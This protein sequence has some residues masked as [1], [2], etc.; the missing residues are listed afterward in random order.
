M[1]LGVDAGLPS[2]PLPIVLPDGVACCRTLQAS[3]LAKLLASNITRRKSEAVRGAMVRD[4]A[5]P[6][7]PTLFISSTVHDLKDIRSGLADV[8]RS[9]G[10]IVYASEAEEFEIRGDRAAL[11]EC[12]DKIRASDFY[13]LIVGG[14]KGSTIEDG[15]L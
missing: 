6:Y 4:S 12:C 14:R 9:Q 15:I 7:A 8:L 11:D 13:V 1:S 10:V 2:G 5:H 3:L